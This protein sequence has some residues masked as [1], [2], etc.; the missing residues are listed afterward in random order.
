MRHPAGLLRLFA[1][2]AVALVAAEPARPA[3]Q[4]PACEPKRLSCIAEC[5]ARY[6]TMDPKRDACIASCVA[7]AN[8]CVREQ[9]GK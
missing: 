3:A 6:F 8:R 5:R 2:A 4:Q 1:S 9:A 7:E